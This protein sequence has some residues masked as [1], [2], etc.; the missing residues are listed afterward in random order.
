MQSCIRLRTRDDPDA[1]ASNFKI[2]DDSP[3]VP[4]KAEAYLAVA[5]PGL[6]KPGDV[7]IKSVR[8]GDLASAFTIIKEMIE[9]VRLNPYLH[10]VLAFER[11]SDA[12]AV[13]AA[14]PGEVMIM[15]PSGIRPKNPRAELPHERVP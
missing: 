9:L 6:E 7:A 1:P 3:T 11:E 12:R 15:T 8:W 5:V 13:Y 10:F 4:F 2:L 14:Q